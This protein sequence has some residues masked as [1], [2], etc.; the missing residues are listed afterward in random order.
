MKGVLLDK[1]G[2]EFE[3][4]KDLDIP[5]PGPGQILVKS[6]V[7]G[8]NPVYAAFLFPFSWPLFFAFKS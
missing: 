6:L 7:T 2:G 3:I 5:R 8:I 1:V 4:A